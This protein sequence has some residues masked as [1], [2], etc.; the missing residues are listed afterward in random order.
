MKSSKIYICKHCGKEFAD[1]YQ[2]T[3]HV[4]KEHGKKHNIRE[5]NIKNYNKNPKL[6]KFCKKPLEYD[7]RINTFCNSSCSASFNNVGVRRH[8]GKKEPKNCAI[9]GI[10]LLGTSNKKFCSQKC[11][12]LYRKR[13]TIEKFLNGESKWKYEVPPTIRNY[14]LEEQ[15][16]KCD[17]CGMGNEWNGKE[18]VFILD[19]I[20]G[21]SY[22]DSRENLRLICPNCDSQLD[23]YKGKNV[24]KGRHYRRERYK[25]GKSY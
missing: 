25:E 21:D 6:C 5:K 3:G 24:G 13:K 9:C 4:T 12:L 10:S 11:N 18:L 15:N 17:I 2:L 20:S 8:G 19:H 14:I 22:D 7:K 1:R 16:N 23:T